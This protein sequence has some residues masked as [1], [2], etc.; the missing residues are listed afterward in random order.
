MVHT[1][2]ELPK[3]RAACKLAAQVL[4]AAGKLVKPGVSTD[5]IDRF[6]HQMVI[7]AGAYPS[8][9]RYGEFPKSVCTSI[10]E[11]V[12]HGIPDSRLLEDGDI[13][14]IDVTVFLDGY[15]GDTSRMFASGNV[16][17]ESRNLM[18]ATE[19]CLHAGIAVC[20]P[21]VP[22]NQIGDACGKAARKSKMTPIEDFCG[23]GVGTVFHAGP[24]VMHVKNRERGK[25]EVGQTFTIE[26]ILCTGK[27]RFKTWSDKWTAVTVDGSRSA[28]YEHTILIT[29]DGH[30][31]LTLP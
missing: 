30:E 23:H 2:E 3:M 12:C 14:N 25:M 6:V 28:Q 31:I 15:H 22:I 1:K 19:Q 27:P 29:P 17:D 8:P 9:L 18:A 16:N 20:G 26:P 5:E 13:V 4:Q 11:V 24:V 10:N 7:D 21:G